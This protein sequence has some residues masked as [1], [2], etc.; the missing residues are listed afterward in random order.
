MANPLVQQGTLNRLL[1]SLVV[2]SYPALN[3]TSSYMGSGFATLEL[4]AP[5]ADLIPTATGGVTSDEPYVIGTITVD[6][7]RSQAL[8]NAWLTQAQTESSIGQ[9]TVYPDS[10]AFSESTL[11]NCV[12]K[13]IHPGV[14]NGKDPVV[15][16]VIDGIF[17]LNENL[18][19][20]A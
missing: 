5:F 8:S 10:K 16:V 6:I 15:R 4:P 20:L 1:T 3:V 17:Y 14:F 7:L 19:N 2:S 12:I 18:W 13:S 9:V 11:D